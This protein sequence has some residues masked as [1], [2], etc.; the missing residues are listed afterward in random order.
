[1]LRHPELQN[2]NNPAR[3]KGEAVLNF[4]PLDKDDKR[5]EDI[6]AFAPP[7]KTTT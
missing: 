1:M 6:R 2:A 3:T 5:H 7:R 4:H